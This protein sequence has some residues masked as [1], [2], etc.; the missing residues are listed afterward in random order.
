MCIPT[1]YEPEAGPSNISLRKLPAASDVIQRQHLKR[2]CAINI[3]RGYRF[4]L[5][6][7]ALFFSSASWSFSGGNTGRSGNPNAGNS[8]CAACHAGGVYDYNLPVLSSTAAVLASSTNNYTLNFTKAAGVDAAAAGFNLSTTGGTLT[9]PD[10]ASNIVIKSGAELTHGTPRLPSAGNFSWDFSWTA[11]ATAGTY[12]FYV[13]ANPVNL[14]GGS[15]LDGIVRCTSF[16]I[17][18][19]AALAAP[20]ANNDSYSTPPNTS[21]TVQA[22]GVLAND[23]DANNDPLT[24]AVVGNPA[25]GTLVLDTGGGFTYTP[26][27][28]FTGSDS[29][30]YKAKDGGGL[31]SNTA[32]VTITVA[33][34]TA[35]VAGNDSYSTAQGSAL[36]VAAPG[37]L[38]NDSDADVN[39]L[40]AMLVANPANGALSLNPNGA[41]TYTPTAGFTGSDSF[42]YQAN[43]GMANSNV[44]TVS[45]T[46]TP[47]AAAAGDGGGGGGGGSLATILLGL[48]TLASVL[49]RRQ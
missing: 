12:R 22:P 11:P 28:G 26:N 16:P 3:R 2:G 49:K 19:N 17:T 5:L 43:D 8:T 7:S 36:M 45:L 21:L 25:S 15:S 1:G 6:L 46:V 30:T 33:G 34:N 18:V 44:A 42:T 47:V 48:F 9:D 13:C 4:S 14:N 31:D 35:P 24:A 23:T 39:S 10:T 27:A 40:T 20:V 38:G 32:T 41:F 37:V 29:F